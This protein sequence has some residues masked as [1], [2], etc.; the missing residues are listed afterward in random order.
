M[1]ELVVS[2]FDVSALSDAAL[3]L[4]KVA[5]QHAYKNLQVRRHT[6]KSAELCS[7]AGLP[8]MAIDDFQTLLVEVCQ[9][10]V[11]VEVIDSAV[12]SRDD[13]PYASWQVFEE[14]QLCEAQVTF[15]IGNHNRIEMLMARLP[16]LRPSKRHGKERV[17]AYYLPGRLHLPAT[18]GA[19][20]EANL[21][22]SDASLAH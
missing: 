15:K 6:I 3:E 18:A 1:A 11:I 2:T 9:A 10:L 21:C 14:V 19:P 13:L 17:G 7:L 12:P 4:M 20:V 16:L 22:A 5:V 8:P